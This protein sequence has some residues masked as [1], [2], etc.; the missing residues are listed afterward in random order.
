MD[1]LAVTYA[2]EVVRF[3][4]ETTIVVPGAFT[5]GTNHFAHAGTP[6]DTAVAAAYEE[7]Y[8][9]L[10][11]VG[12]R[13]AALEPADADPSEVARQVA[14][15]VDLPAGHRPFRVH[16]DPS[17]DGAAEVFDLGDRIRSDFY[18][19]IGLPDLFH[20]PAGV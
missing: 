8:A 16:V 3:G 1:S 4:I 12:A 14:R 19:R 10:A 5:G 18:R 17:H 15:V 20:Q 2:A 11:Q 13:L 6:E 7:R 9:D